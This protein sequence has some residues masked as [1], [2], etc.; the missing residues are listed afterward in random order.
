MRTQLLAELRDGRGDD[1]AA[2]A[3]AVGE[4]ALFSGVSGGEPAEIRVYDDALLVVGAAGSERISFSFAGPVRS[5][6]Y[7]VTVEV[8]GREPVILSRLGRRTGELAD[9]LTERLRQA[10]VP[11]GA[12]W[13]DRIA[14][15]L[16]N[17]P[18][19]CGA[20]DPDRGV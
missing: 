1:A 9:L 17:L 13:P 12:R 16:A 7:T 10:R 2:A 19:D 8:A 15:L 3:A 4:P 18:I 14:A 6:D 20:G 5:R 11:H